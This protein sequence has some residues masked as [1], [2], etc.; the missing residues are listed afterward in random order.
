MTQ[1]PSDADLAI[2]S[3]FTEVGIIEQ[4]ARTAF[5][6]QLPDGLQMAHFGLL[7]HMVR[8][9]DGWTPARLAK[10][11]QLTKGAIS[12]SLARLEARGLI[13]TEPDADDRRSKRVFITEAGRGAWRDCV[14]ALMPG[15]ARIGEELGV[16]VFE[17][18]LPALQSVRAWLDAERA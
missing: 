17:Q 1:A 6:R 4:L 16:E 18:A 8:L 10:A 7:N 15:I 2:F 9:G 14:A 12:N 3:F 11:F 13:R 5:T